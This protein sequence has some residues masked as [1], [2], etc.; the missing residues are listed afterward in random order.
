MEALLQEIAFAAALAVEAIAILLIAIGSVEAVFGIARVMFSANSTGTGRRDVW[1][2]LARWLVAALTFQLCGGHHQHVARAGL[3]GGRPS[4]GDRGD[5]DVPELLSRSR[6]REHAPA[7]GSARTARVN[8]DGS[9]AGGT[10]SEAPA[11][12][13]QAELD[14]SAREWQAKPQGG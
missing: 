3:G 11:G 2:N 12:V 1:L 14:R 9:A 13:D 10:A 6:G 4:R 8:P 5:P 7:A